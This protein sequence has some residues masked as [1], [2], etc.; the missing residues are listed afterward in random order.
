MRKAM[1]L[2]LLGGLSLLLAAGCDKFGGEQQYSRAEGEP[3]IFGVTSGAGVFPDPESG[4]GSGV[5]SEAEESCV[6]F[7]VLEE[8]EEGVGVLE[9]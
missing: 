9:G 3:V 1:N 5:F 8:S 4:V 2:F 7:G 6:G